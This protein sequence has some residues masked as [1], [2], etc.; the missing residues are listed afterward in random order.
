MQVKPMSYRLAPNQDNSCPISKNGDFA[1]CKGPS[2]RRQPRPVYRSSIAMRQCHCSV[3]YI[4]LTS[5]LLSSHPKRVDI[6]SK[7]Q[8]SIS[9]LSKSFPSMT[10]KVCLWCYTRVRHRN[11]M[12]RQITT[13]GQ[14]FIHCTTQLTSPMGLVR[15]DAT[16]QQQPQCCCIKVQILDSTPINMLYSL[17]SEVYLY[18]SGTPYTYPIRFQYYTKQR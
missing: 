11:K 10:E 12:P 5:I 1:S 14:V 4:A 3:K 16:Q 2:S 7:S 6:F 15:L 13:Q 18:I 8:L 17:G 9:Q